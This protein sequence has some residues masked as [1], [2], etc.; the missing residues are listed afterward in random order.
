[1]TFRRRCSQQTKLISE[2]V[3]VHVNFV[4]AHKLAIKT[5]EEAQAVF[6]NALPP[7]ITPPQCQQHVM[8][9]ADQDDGVSRKRPRS[10]PLRQDL[11]SSDSE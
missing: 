9:A 7:T 4:E 1:M 6:T 3:T 8:S 2:L 10:P 11:N 5:H